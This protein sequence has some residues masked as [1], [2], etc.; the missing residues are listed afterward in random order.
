MECGVEPCQLKMKTNLIQQVL[1]AFMDRDRS[2]YKDYDAIDIAI[3]CSPLKCEIDGAQSIF[4]QQYRQ[5]QLASCNYPFNNHMIC[6]RPHVNHLGKTVYRVSERASIR[7]PVSCPHLLHTIQ[8]WLQ[9]YA[10][11]LLGRVD[12]KWLN[13]VTFCRVDNKRL[14]APAKTLFQRRHDFDPAA[15]SKSSVSL[16]FQCLSIFSIDRFFSTTCDRLAQT[17]KDSQT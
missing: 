10:H 15:Q 11:L 8:R 17:I 3:D 12:H 6:I 2:F 7:I 9:L 1:S 14:N 13:V 4:Y 16:M 5:L